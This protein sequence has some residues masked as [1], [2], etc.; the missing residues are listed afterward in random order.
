MAENEAPKKP[1]KTK[2]VTG[3]V[4]LSTGSFDA[5]NPLLL[6]AAADAFK[7]QTQGDVTITSVR[8]A[9][10]HVGKSVIYDVAG[11]VAA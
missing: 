5:S 4:V 11:E 7:A 9:K 6:D 1:T 2:T 10:H 3:Q 8:V